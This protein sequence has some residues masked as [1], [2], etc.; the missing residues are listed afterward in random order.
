MASSRKPRPATKKPKKPVSKKP[1]PKK[2]VSKKPAAKRSPSKKPVAKRPPTKN[3]AAKKVQERAPAATKPEVAPAAAIAPLYLVEPAAPYT[4]WMLCLADTHSPIDLFEE[5]GHSGNGYAW[6]SVARVTIERAKLPAA[7]IDFNSEGG[8]F[9]AE[10][11]SRDALVGLGRELASL[12]RDPEAL[13][14][15]IRAVPEDD[16]DD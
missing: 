1:A 3:P 7:G 5:E 12:L 15:A 8:T 10:S 2:P 4:H 6:D 16:W 9:V 11:D 13:R 14:Q